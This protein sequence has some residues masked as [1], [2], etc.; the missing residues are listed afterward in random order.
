M[1]P[2]YP[3]IHV[4][5]HYH[6]ARTAIGRPSLEVHTPAQLVVPPTITL[7]LTHLCTLTS[8]PHQPGPQD[9]HSI[10]AHTQPAPQKPP[11][12]NPG[13]C[14]HYQ[15]IRGTLA[16]TTVGTI[17]HHIKLSAKLARNRIS[18][19]LPG[20]QRPAPQRRRLRRPMCKYDTNIVLIP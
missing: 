15:H 9:D 19:H 20:S 12:Y 6:N 13:Q 7:I 18:P 8:A 1:S 17:H 3:I 16:G 14:H 11:I 4:S 10:Q 2:S 5:H